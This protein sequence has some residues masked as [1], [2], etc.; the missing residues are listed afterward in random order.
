MGLEGLK[1]LNQHVFESKYTVETFEIPQ[2]CMHK[3]ITV[4]VLLKLSTA[5]FDLR[6]KSAE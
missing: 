5:T 2:S 3:E 1:H 4:C 6:V